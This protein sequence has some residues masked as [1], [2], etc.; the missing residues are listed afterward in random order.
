MKDRIL[1]KQTKLK[2]IYMSLTLP[3][4]LGTTLQR[5]RLDGNF[6]FADYLVF[7]FHSVTTDSQLSWLEPTQRSGHTLDLII[8]RDLDG[9]SDHA[10]L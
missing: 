4:L 8:T 9:L 3:R 6:G 7:A 10:H 2:V 5:T 1:T